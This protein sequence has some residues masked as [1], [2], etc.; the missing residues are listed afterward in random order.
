MRAAPFDIHPVS[1]NFTQLVGSIS[2]T[3]RKILIKED[4]TFSVVAGNAPVS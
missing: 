4:H 2:C 3:P 1:T